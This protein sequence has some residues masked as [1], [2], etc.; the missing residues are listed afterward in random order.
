MLMTAMLHSPESARIT[1]VPS[2]APTTR[3][4]R[5]AAVGSRRAPIRAAPLLARG[6]VAVQ[7]LAQIGERREIAPH[8]RLKAIGDDGCRPI[9]LE[10]L[11]HQRNGHAGDGA[12]L[13]RDH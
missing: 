3:T 11:V 1:G 2:Y 5:S 8:V 7:R 9:R 6:A 10:G 12:D 4:N 13:D